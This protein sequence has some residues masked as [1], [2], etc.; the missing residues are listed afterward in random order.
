[1][2][3]AVLVGLACA[4]ILAAAAGLCVRRYRRRA[5]AVAARKASAEAPLHFQPP[6]KPTAVRSPTG[7]PA[8]Y[9]LKKSPSPTSGGGSMPPLTARSPPGVSVIILF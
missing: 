2:A 7:A 8:H 3:P 4:A 6:R 1:M 9:Y 5:D